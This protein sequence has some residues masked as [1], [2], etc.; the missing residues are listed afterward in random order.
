[1]AIKFYNKHR[2]LPQGLDVALPPNHLT[3]LWLLFDHAGY[4]GWVPIT[5][6]DIALVL[7]VHINSVFAYLW[8]LRSLGL[9]ERGYAR[10]RITPSIAA[11]VA[12]GS[13]E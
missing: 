8:K 13:H 6:R 5:Q 9:I 1:M 4:D 12:G 11:M 3:I 10:W 2:P 7:G